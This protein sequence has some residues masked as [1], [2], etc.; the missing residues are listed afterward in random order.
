MTTIRAD[1]RLKHAGNRS[2]NKGKKYRGKEEE[3]FHILERDFK[4]R[5]S[6]IPSIG[7]T[8]YY[9]LS[10]FVKAYNA[11]GLVQNAAMHQLSLKSS[12]AIEIELRKPLGQKNPLKKDNANRFH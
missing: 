3:T 2:A 1:R 9:Y 7:K 4:S 5:E 11:F 10:S 12:E 8:K 6:T